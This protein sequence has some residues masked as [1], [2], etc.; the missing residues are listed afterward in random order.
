MPDLSLAPQAISELARILSARGNPLR[1]ETYSSPGD[2][3]LRA[4]TP[5][6]TV[7]VIADRAQ[8]FVDLAPPGV[9]D[10]FDTEVWSACLSGAPVS[11]QLV[12]LDSQVAWIMKFLDEDVR[13]RYSIESLRQE[14]Q[15][16]AHGRLGFQQ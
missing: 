5:A 2:Q 16:R 11:L 7:Q 1:T 10:Y 3:V 9:D 6:G 8:W 14:R 15:R 4:R 13:T 12:S